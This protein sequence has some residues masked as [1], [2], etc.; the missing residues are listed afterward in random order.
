M[1]IQ[2]KI[3]LYHRM[4]EVCFWNDNEETCY[5]EEDVLANQV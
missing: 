2:V 3:F 1:S 4:P 5:W